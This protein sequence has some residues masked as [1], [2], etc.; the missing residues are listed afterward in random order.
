L[1]LPATASRLISAIAAP[2][3]ALSF[4]PYLALAPHALGVMTPHVAPEAKPHQNPERLLIP[5]QVLISMLETSKYHH[6]TFI[7]DP[8]EL[9]AHPS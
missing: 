7:V 6:C 4:R 8:H 5:T 1:S 2:F 3:P 9:H